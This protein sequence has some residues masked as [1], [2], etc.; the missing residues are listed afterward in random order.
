MP[1][2]TIETLLLIFTITITLKPSLLFQ[3]I[4]SDTGKN[5]GDDDRNG[6]DR[7]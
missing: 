6:G 7:G 3:L 5:G 2:I 4:I 1:K